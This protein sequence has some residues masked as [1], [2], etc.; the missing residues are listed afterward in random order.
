M[1][2]LD[3]ELDK[4]NSAIRQIRKRDKDCKIVAVIDRPVFEVGETL[5]LGVDDYIKRGELNE[6]GIRL[7]LL[8][9]R[10][11]PI[12]AGQVFFH[13]DFS[14][15]E[16]LSLLRYRD[17]EISLSKTERLILYELF[18]CGGSIDSKLLIQRVWDDDMIVGT[19]RLQFHISVLRRKIRTLSERELIRTIK[20]RGYGLV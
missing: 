4:T 19:N 16:E 14:L 13:G 17:R 2:S 20:G 5:R 18:G 10:I 11:A 6:L 7:W 8:K 15:H 3:R 9:R 1:L 12:N